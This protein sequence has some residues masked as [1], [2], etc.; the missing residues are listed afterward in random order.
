MMTT[1]RATQRQVIL[2]NEVKNLFIYKD[3]PKSKRKDFIIKSK[4]VKD[5]LRDKKV[6]M[7]ELSKK[8]KININTMYKIFA[9]R[10]VDLKIVK[11]F[12]KFFNVEQ[13]LIFE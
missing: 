5:L 3:K 1:E 8:I 2:E 6:R 11:K 9:G 12:T 4:V 7:T 13:D 10:L